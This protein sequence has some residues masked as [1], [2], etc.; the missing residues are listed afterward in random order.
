MA[1]VKLTKKNIFPGDIAS[2]PQGPREIVL[3]YLPF[4]KIDKLVKND[5]RLLYLTNDLEFWLR[6]LQAEGY[7]LP[8]GFADWI[9]AW[10]VG[11]L[12]E[13][14]RCLLVIEPHYYGDPLFKYAEKLTS[15]SLDIYPL[16]IRELLAPAVENF[17]SEISEIKDLYE[18]WIKIKDQ[19]KFQRDFIL[20]RES[21][22]RCINMEFTSRSNNRAVP[23]TLTEFADRHG[24]FSA[25]SPFSYS[26]KDDLLNILKQLRNGDA[27]TISTV[28]DKKHLFL[29]EG[30]LYPFFR[31]SGS[32]GGEYYFPKEALPWLE[33]IHPL[34]KEDLPVYNPIFKLRGFLDKT[35]KI[36]YMACRNAKGVIVSITYQWNTYEDVD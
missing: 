1:L 11:S 8:L 25:K 16:G 9:N 27:I 26:S 2:L 13:F 19:M 36:H 4:Q 22:N 18:S 15:I 24:D 34:Y 29:Y 20:L 7:V 5:Q 35:E 31:S 3:M 6:R 17:N 10:R 23:V 14:V 12:I 21:N 33:K 28:R 30:E 32:K